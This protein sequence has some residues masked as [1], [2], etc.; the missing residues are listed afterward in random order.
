MLK[1]KNKDDFPRPEKHSIILSSYHS[2][3]FLKKR[4]TPAFFPS[5]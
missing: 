2:I 1:T 3:I 5:L 4:A